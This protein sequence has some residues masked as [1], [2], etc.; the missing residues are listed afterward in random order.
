ML[1]SPQS[2]N[3]FG[4]EDELTVKLLSRNS[5]GVGL[6][7]AGKAFLAEAQGVMVRA[8]GAKKAVSELSKARSVVFE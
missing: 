8:D 3:H 6:T 5:R 1:H 2:V 4:L 7:A